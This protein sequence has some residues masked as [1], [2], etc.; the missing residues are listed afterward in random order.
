MLNALS[1]LR[2]PHYMIP[3]KVKRPC[4]MVLVLML[5]TGA[6]FAR[7]GEKGVAL[8]DADIARRF[9]ERRQSV[10]VHFD[11]REIVQEI[12]NASTLN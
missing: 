8:S 2:Q 1:Y 10:L 11:D 7:E 12:F 4:I 6:L 5:S 9:E 3:T